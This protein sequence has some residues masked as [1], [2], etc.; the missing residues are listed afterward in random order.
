MRFTV[1]LAAT[2]SACV[3]P[4]CTSQMAYESGQAWQRNAC[5]K[6]IDMQERQRCMAR[7]NLPYDR[8]QR[9]ADEARG[10]TSP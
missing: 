5:D 3:L 4:A 2:L 6:I 8:Y 10:T 9:Q 1:F 7:V